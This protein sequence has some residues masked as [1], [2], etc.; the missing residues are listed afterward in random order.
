M[1]HGTHLGLLPPL[2]LLNQKSVKWYANTTDST[3]ANI[4]V[5]PAGPAQSPGGVP[6]S[7]GAH[8]AADD[9]SGARPQLAG[10][11]AEIQCIS[12]EQG[13]GALVS[14]RAVQPHPLNTHSLNRGCI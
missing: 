10:G 14:A 6:R 4:S 5:L 13:E 1:R 11:G 3:T 7:A 12:N 8:Q 9:N 2:V